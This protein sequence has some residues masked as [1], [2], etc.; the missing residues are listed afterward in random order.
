MYLFKK[1][2]GKGKNRLQIG[3]IAVCLSLLSGCATM[4][5]ENVDIN[6]LITDI[7]NL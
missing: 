5:W 4:Q 3:I 7:N 6:Q 1:P 2:N